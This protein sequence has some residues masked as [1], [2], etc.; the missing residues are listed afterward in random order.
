MGAIVAMSQREAMSPL[1]YE[2]DVRLEVLQRKVQGL[3]SAVLLERL[4]IINR[5]LRAGILREE[6]AWV[7]SQLAK[8]KERA[9]Q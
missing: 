9:S 6:A 1:L 4:T 5:N 7:E 2:I 8:A 3:L